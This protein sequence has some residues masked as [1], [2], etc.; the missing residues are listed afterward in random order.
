MR[1]ES[2]SG[3]PMD[4]NREQRQR[5]PEM[6][7]RAV[8]LEDGLG[9]KAARMGMPG[10]DR[11]QT[12]N[13]VHRH[14]PRRRTPWVGAHRATR[15]VSSLPQA[16]K[17]PTGRSSYR[18]RWTTVKR[19]PRTAPQWFDVLDLMAF[20]KEGRLR[21]KV[22]GLSPS[23]PRLVRSSAENPVVPGNSRPGTSRARSD[24]VSLCALGV[25]CVRYSALGE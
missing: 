17:I 18:K 21:P 15:E 4:G 5:L 10:G 13:P 9:G 14:G 16:G 6:L 19:F 7:A 1:R 24:S 20:A 25:L 23:R 3:P 12:R 8:R 11:G 2:G 22:A